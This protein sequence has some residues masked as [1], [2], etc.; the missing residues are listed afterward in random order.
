MR[1]L[2]LQVRTDFRNTKLPSLFLSLVL[3]LTMSISSAPESNAA[4]LQ[5]TAISQASWFSNVTVN[6]SGDNVSIASDGIP[7]WMAEKYS[8]PNA[9]IVVPTSASD[10]TLDFAT[11]LVS[12][13]NLNYSITLSP[14][15]AS[16]PTTTTLGPIGILVNGA[17][18]YNP[19]EGDGKTVAVGSNV[20]LTDTNGVKWGFLD[21]CN[22][23][24]GMGG[25]YHYHGM[26]PC[27]TSVIDKVGGPSHILGIAFDGFLIYGDRDISGKIISSTQLDS[28]NGIT[29]P[30]PEF[31]AGVY[32]YVLTEEKSNKSTIN[33]FTGT[34][35]ISKSGSQQQ[36][37][38]APM[39]GMGGPQQQGGMAPMPGMGGPSQTPQQPQ[40][41]PVVV[42][43]TI[44]AAPT[45]TPTPTFTT[46]YKAVKVTQL[47]C[48]KGK[49]K[50][51]VTTNTC[52]TGYKRLSS[53]SITKYVAT[54][55]TVQP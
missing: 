41:Q 43:P 50:K 44:S 51:S 18:L 5:Q 21:T 48:Q 23:H 12:K 55:L 40:A 28:C 17:V 38:M 46:L 35:T 24:P 2:R 3:L 32:H 27:V 7:N 14:T 42:A 49:V 13:Q 19:F 8:K 39:P 29:S 22:G 45:A 53:K 34:S 1:N 47:V 6:F 4:S 26:P 37:G 31:P 10:V 54:N 9:G 36:G 33:C 15:K 52:P 20:Y 11:N 25:M 16:A 30:T